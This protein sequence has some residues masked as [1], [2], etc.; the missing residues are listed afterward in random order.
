MQGRYGVLPK[1]FL[2]NNNYMLAR[3]AKV[4]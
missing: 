2:Q 4:M 3:T 1:K